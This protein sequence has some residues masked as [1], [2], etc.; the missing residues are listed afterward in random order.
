MMILVSW[1]MKVKLLSHFTKQVH[2]SPSKGPPLFCLHSPLGI[3]SIPRRQ[4]L[5]LLKLPDTNQS[6][7]K[8]LHSFE[9]TFWSSAA[10]KLAYFFHLHQLVKNLN[11]ANKAPLV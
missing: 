10:L 6:W 4:P 2:L 11:F 9:D 1:H 5:L 3:S 8:L 7:S